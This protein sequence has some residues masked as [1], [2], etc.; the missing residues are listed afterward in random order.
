MKVSRLPLPEVTLCA[1]TSVNVSATVEA[2]RASTEQIKFGDAIL[3]SDIAPEGL[4][5][6]LRHVHIAPLRSARDY[7]LFMLKQLAEHVRTSHCLVVQWD[8]FV[9]DARQWDPQFLRCDYVGAP[10]PQFADYH[11]V[12]NGGFSLRS[13]KLLQACRDPEFKASHPEDLAIGRVN[14]EWL[15]RERGIVFADRAMAERFAFE[16]TRPN[17]PTFGFHGIFNMVP[18]LGADKFWR[19]YEMLDD[20]RTAFVDYPR[21]LSQLLR[22]PAGVRQAA[23]L[24]LDRLRRSEGQA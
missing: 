13:C 18:L 20:R 11:D 17:G 22:S 4:P 7:S 21:L 10:W 2:L 14:R 6:P 12:G 23:R 9:I 19:M 8:G 16:R 3:F 15:E 5:A 1:A 24:T